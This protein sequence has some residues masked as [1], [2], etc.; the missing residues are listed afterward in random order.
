MGF[1]VVQMKGYDLFQGEIIMNYWKYI[2]EIKKSS[3]PELLHGPFNQTWHK[4]PW[5]KGI[6]VWLK[7]H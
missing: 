2:D 1:K 4:A 5:V 6:E 7:N 3:S